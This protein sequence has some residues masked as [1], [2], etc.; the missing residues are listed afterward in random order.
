MMNAKGLI[1][2]VLEGGVSNPKSLAN[3]LNDPVT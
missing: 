1:R 2:Q 3:T